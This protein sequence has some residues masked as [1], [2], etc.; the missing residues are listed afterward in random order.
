MF[1]VDKVGRII[2]ANLSGYAMVAGAI[3]IRAPNG[4]LDQPTK[5]DIPRRSEGMLVPFLAAIMGLINALEVRDKPWKFWGGM[6]SAAA[7]VGFGVLQLV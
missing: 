4:R 7:L 3:A 2:H 6:L 1:I 5:A